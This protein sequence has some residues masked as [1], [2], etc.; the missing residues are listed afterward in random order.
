MFVPIQDIEGYIRALRHNGTPEDELVKIREKHIAHMPPPPEP[1]PKKWTH[2]YTFTDQIKIRLE[3][4]GDRVHFKWSAPF[5]ELHKYMY[6]GKPIPLAVRVK[7]LL[8][9]GA[10]D[11]YVKNV[12][13]KNNEWFT[14]EN[15]DKQ[16]K[17]LE[18]IFGLDPVKKVIKSVKKKPISNS[19]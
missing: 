10:P 14:E 18:R 13:K 19:K 8:K 3:V 16:Q 1:K 15:M 17:I 6:T 7:C 4:K 5:E 2:G 12:I 11:E 9:A